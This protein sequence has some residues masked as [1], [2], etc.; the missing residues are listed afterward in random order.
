MSLHAVVPEHGDDPE[1]DPMQE[2]KNRVSAWHGFA[3]DVVIIVSMTILTA[4]R[5]AQL[6]VFIAIVGPIVGARLSA[7]RYMRDGGGGPGGSALAAV[8]LGLWLLLRRPAG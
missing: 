2:E 8:G 3:L 7:L 5:I 6:T 4:L 1:E